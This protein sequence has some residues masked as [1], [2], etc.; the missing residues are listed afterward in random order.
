LAGGRLIISEMPRVK[1]RMER[2]RGY[3]SVVLR[4][5]SVH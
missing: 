2:R 1:S 5:D 4:A 3:W